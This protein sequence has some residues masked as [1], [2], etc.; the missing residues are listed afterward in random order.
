MTELAEFIE[1]RDKLALSID[2]GYTPEGFK[3]VVNAMTHVINLVID[4][5][6]L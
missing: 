5:M 1:E 4:G 2:A 3:V 6:G